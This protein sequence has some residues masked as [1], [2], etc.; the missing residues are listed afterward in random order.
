MSCWGGLALGGVPLDFHEN[1][2]LPTPFLGHDL[3]DHPRTCK[4]LIT[5]HGHRKSPKNRAGPLPNGRF[6]AEKHG[7][8]PITT[9]DTWEPILQVLPLQKVKL[10]Q[11]Q[12]ANLVGCPLAP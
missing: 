3:E 8:D 12:E 1:H 4:W 5:M 11:V 10:I 2:P 9:C 7:G 6:M